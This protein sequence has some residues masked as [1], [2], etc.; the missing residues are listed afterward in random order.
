MATTIKVFGNIRDVSRFAKSCVVTIKLLNGPISEDPNLIAPTEVVQTTDGTGYFEAQI[1]LGDYSL[2]IGNDQILFSVTDVSSGDQNVV[3]LI[4]SDL[5][6]TKQ[7]Y[8]S[9]WNGIRQGNIQFLPIASPGLPTASTISSGGAVFGLDGDQ[10]RYY[11]TFVTALGETLPSSAVTV[12]LTGNTPGSGNFIRITFNVAD[13]VTNVVTKRL[14]RSASGALDGTMIILAEL[15]PATATYDDKQTYADTSGIT[16]TDEPIANTTAGGIYSG[17]NLIATATN[18]T[19]LDVSSRLLIPQKSTLFDR[20]ISQVIDAIGAFVYPYFLMRAEGNEYKIG[21][22]FT[23]GAEVY[24]LVPPPPLSGYTGSRV[25][26]EDGTWATPSG[27]GGGVRFDTGTTVTVTPSDRYVWCPNVTS[28]ILPNAA[29]IPDGW[30][31]KIYFG[32]VS[33]LDCTITTDLTLSFGF[34]EFTT[35]HTYMGNLSDDIYPAWIVLGK[36]GTSL[37]LLEDSNVSGA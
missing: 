11:V 13:V 19:G 16:P 20:E 8:S 21:N 4:T 22:I 10:Y 15:D 2:N 34:S 3:N 30:V 9:N 36:N 33:S 26:Q 25:L 37:E 24:G 5:T 1:G 32:M 18:E 7:P 27:G 14:W 35:G 28:L 23:G 31:V 6:Y 17:N 29:D 12:D